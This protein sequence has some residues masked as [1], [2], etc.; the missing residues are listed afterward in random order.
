[1]IELAFD[2]VVD[3]CATNRAGST[4]L[5]LALDLP[6]SLEPLYCG[7]ILVSLRNVCWVKGFGHNWIRLL[8]LRRAPRLASRLLEV[9]DVESFMLR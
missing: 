6:K 9:L 2:A 7:S 5:G 8:F 3:T 1:L 4:L